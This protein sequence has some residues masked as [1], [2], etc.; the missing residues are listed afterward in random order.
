MQ[1]FYPFVPQRAKRQASC[2]FRCKNK[3]LLLCPGVMMLLWLFFYINFLGLKWP[4]FPINKPNMR[5]GREMVSQFKSYW[6]IV[7]RSVKAKGH[8]F[9][10]SYEICGGKHSIMAS[11]LS[12]QNEQYDIISILF[13]AV[14]TVY[15]ALYVQ[16]LTAGLECVWL[17]DNYCILQQS[18]PFIIQ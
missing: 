18:L 16:Q 17:E 15:A 9:L 11:N 13:Y 14:K 1:Y 6:V 2:T 8:I 12:W 4:S 3:W 5:D 10:L 7:S